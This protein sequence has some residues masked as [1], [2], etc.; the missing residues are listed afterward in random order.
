MLSNASVRL[1]EQ[2]RI[3]KVLFVTFRKE[4]VFHLAK[5]KLRRGTSP[6]F[7]VNGI[8]LGQ[9][10]I[11]FSRPPPPPNPTNPAFPKPPVGMAAACSEQVQ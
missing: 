8:P 4:V 7:S 9:V 10:V 2:H 1:K 5:N 6:V 3:S 11:Y